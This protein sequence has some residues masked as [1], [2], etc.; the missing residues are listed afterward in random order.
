MRPH[1]Y[2]D[3]RS[4][5]ICR[6]RLRGD[7]LIT[8][9]YSPSMEHAP[10]IVTLFSSAWVSKALAYV[11]YDTLLGS[12]AASTLAYLRESGVDFSEFVDAPEKLTTA[13]DIFERRIRFWEC[14]PLPVSRSAVVC[15]ADA[16]VLVGSFRESSILL[17]K[18]KFFDYSELLGVDKS[19]WL[20]DFLDGDFAVFRLTPDKY[21]YV[22]APVDG[23][24]IDTYEIDGEHHSCNPSATISPLASYSKNRRVVTVV[25]TDVNGGSGV[26]L[27][28]IVHVVALMVGKIVQCYSQHQY[29]APAQLSPS[30]FI[31]RGQPIT[32]FRPGSST[33][34]LLFQQGRI[35][36]CEDL[37]INRFR[38]AVKSRFSI[39]FEQHVVETDVTVR[40]ALAWREADSI[41]R[42]RRG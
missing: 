41:F 3:R 5:E 14:R 8:A 29:D 21:H 2:I 22:H 40:S 9:L 1:E 13:R 35:R 4:G 25:D 23:I 37:L 42:K 7:Q 26:G 39:G 30:T 6:E 32:M 12:S 33:V 19:F 24:V 20:E 15:P 34:V 11:N 18:N 28:A 16:R 17:I 36:F 10:G 38:P 27:V 31:K